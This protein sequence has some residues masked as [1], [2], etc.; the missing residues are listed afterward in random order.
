M[1]LPQGEKKYLTK[2]NMGTV[3][4][5]LIIE[6]L[7]KIHKKLAGNITLNGVKL[8]SVLRSGTKKRCPSH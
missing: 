7:I 2:S 8:D 4:R 6:K 1:L 5:N 3:F